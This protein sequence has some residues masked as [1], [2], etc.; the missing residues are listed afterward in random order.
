[1]LFGGGINSYHQESGS[2]FYKCM[3]KWLAL[4]LEFQV[5]R[6]IKKNISISTSNISVFF[7]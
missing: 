1:M 4:V 5:L 6:P 2:V 3:L 7:L